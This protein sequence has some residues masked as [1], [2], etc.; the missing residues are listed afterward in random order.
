ML[1]TG[2]VVLMAER[3]LC[4]QEAMGSNPIGSI[5]AGSSNGRTSRW[6]REGYG[7]KSHL[8]HVPEDTVT[9]ECPVCEEKSLTLDPDSG[10]IL[11][12]PIV[13]LIHGA[14]DGDSFDITGFCYEC[15]HEEHKTLTIEVNY[16]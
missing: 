15:G 2:R 4:K 10:T 6:L 3:L 8:V 11:G 7:F 5:R 14:D 1:Y 16:E 9:K 12:N 13:G